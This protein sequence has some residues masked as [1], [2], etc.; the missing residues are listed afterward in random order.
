MPS[1]RRRVGESEEREGPDRSR[2]TGFRER[3]RDFLHENVAQ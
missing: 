3:R 2:Q 1:E